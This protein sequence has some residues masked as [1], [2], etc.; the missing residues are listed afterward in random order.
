MNNA[1]S[2]ADL[3]AGYEALRAAALGSRPAESPKGLALLLGQGLPGWIRGWTMPAAARSPAAVTGRA[4]SAAG[5][6]SELVRLLAEM[7]L[8]QGRRLAVP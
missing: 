5:P 3:A 6:S 2:A 7:A 1:F 8:G 4:E